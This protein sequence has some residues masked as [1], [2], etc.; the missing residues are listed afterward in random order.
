MDNWPRAALPLPSMRVAFHI[1]DPLTDGVAAIALSWVRQLSMQYP[2][3]RY[4]VLSE[5][6]LPDPVDRLS[7]GSF[8]WI[9]LP[10]RFPLFPFWSDAIFFHKLSL[11]K[12]DVFIST[13]PDKPVFARC[14]QARVTAKAGLATDSNET[15]FA[16]LLSSH[17]TVL[18]TD[19][20]LAIK[21]EWSLGRE[22]FML[23]GPLPSESMLTLLLQAFSLFKHRQQSGLKLLLPFS[24]SGRYPVLASK[25]DQY[26][27]RQSLVITGSI[28][29]EQV[30]Q[31]TG[32][33]YALLSVGSPGAALLASAQ[34]WRVGVPL[35]T[36]P[37]LDLSCLTQDSVLFA[38]EPTKEALATI[39]MQI[40]KD[41]SLRLALIRQGQRCLSAADAPFVTASIR[42]S[43]QQLI[44]GAATV[45][46]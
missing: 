27:Y 24:L 5:Y 20:K 16:P 7:K 43:L 12:P 23:T 28:A 3:D 40:Y 42:T 21:E 26:K 29:A 8:A 25:I 36:L 13:Y 37:D 35:L 38:S 34:S 31:L 46:A 15:S 39:M 19:Q 9:V 22:Y 18:N 44:T 2:E 32:A 6:P 14:K 11:F 30:A 41:E 4:V 33:A 45:G 10:R 1:G 17:Y